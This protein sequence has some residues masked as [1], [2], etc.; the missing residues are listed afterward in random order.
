MMRTKFDGTMHNRAMRMWEQGVVIREM[1]DRLGVSF[2][3]MRYHIRKNRFDFPLR[4]EP[5]AHRR[6][7]NLM[8]SGKLK[9]A[10]EMWADGEPYK[11]I[12]YKIG[13]E[14]D[15]LRTFISTHRQ[16]FPRRREY[17]RVSPEDADRIRD[18]RRSSMTLREIADEL[19]LSVTTIWRYTR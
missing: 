19:G 16:W 9:D 14:Y 13:V 5:K 18:M 8:S 7:M 11:V 12:A 17:N 1:A 4:V 10:I 15:Y 6:R 3:A 2:N